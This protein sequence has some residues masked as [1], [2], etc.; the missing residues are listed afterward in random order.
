MNPQEATELAR[1]HAIADKLQSY[2]KNASDKSWRPHHWV[3]SALIEAYE[4]GRSGNVR[5]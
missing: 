2:T 5:R 1:K 3:V 4:L